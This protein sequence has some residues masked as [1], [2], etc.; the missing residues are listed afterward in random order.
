MPTLLIADDEPSIRRTLREILEYEGYAVE[1]AADGDEALLKARGGDIDLVLL[2]IKMPKMDG[3]EVLKAMREDA[4]LKSIPV[5]MLTSSCE[6]RDVLE[7]YALG[8]NAYVVKPV[9]FGDFIEAVKQLGMF[10]AVVNQA[11][12]G[13]VER[14][15]A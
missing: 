13:S 10:W 7:S 6:E 12:P 1:E 8:V 2:D 15:A 14:R 4:N 3:L 5:V 11:P 9:A